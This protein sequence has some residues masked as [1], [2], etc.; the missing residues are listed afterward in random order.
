MVFKNIKKNFKV[1]LI[2]F[3]LIL[4]AL[5]L[6]KY[7][8]ILN[9]LYNNLN[10]NQKTI[11]LSILSNEKTTLKI[12]NDE[13][14]KFL[15]ETEQ[16]LLNFEKIKIKNFEKKNELKNNTSK[17]VPYKN[18]Y[19]S[20]Y[21]EAYKNKI[22]IMDPKGNFFFTELKEINGRD[23]NLT[24]IKK[25]LNINIDKARDFLI[26]DDLIY[27][28]TIINENNCQKI[29]ILKKN[30]NLEKLNFI[31]LFSKKFCDEDLNLQ[32][33]RIEIFVDENF[34]KKILLS[35]NTD[36]TVYQSQKNYISL[37]QKNESI[38]GKI[39]SIDI[40][41]G[42][43]EIYSKGHRN[44]LGIYYDKVSK[45]ILVSENGPKGGDEINLIKQGKNYGWNIS[46]YGE[47]YYNDGDNLIDYKKSHKNFGFVEPIYTF[48]TAVAPTEIIKIEKNKFS[49]YWD[50][51]FVLG[52][53]VGRSLYRIKFQFDLERILFIEKIYLGERV[54]DLYFDNNNEMIL[55]A[56]EDSGSIGI[57]KVKRET[58]NKN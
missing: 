4:L 43:Y 58:N 57:L 49:Q 15:P 32:A 34:N 48:I 52:S 54:R 9:N 13:K 22:I 10:N 41:N 45:N 50:D 21:I 37:A 14:T 19:K 17:W 38:F 16:L 25:N 2:V 23:I 46:S 40:L 39:I 28:S 30:L 6:K 35:T 11:A 8:S 26:D 24:E 12:F 56:L 29:I 3:F 55:M 18:K 7:D 51:N 47:K 44:I 20:F 31:E 36:E 1:S 33:G 53:L 5:A 27:L 42:T